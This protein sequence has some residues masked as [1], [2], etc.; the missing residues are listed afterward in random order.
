MSTAVVPS[1]SVSFVCLPLVS[2][3]I[4]VALSA[5]GTLWA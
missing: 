1:L 2:G 4:S 3:F 5:V